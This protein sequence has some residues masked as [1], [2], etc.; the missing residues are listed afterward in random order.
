MQIIGLLPVLSVRGSKGRKAMVTSYHQDLRKTVYSC[1]HSPTPA[2]LRR[3][4]GTGR[5]QEVTDI[6]HILHVQCYVVR[7]DRRRW[8]GNHSWHTYLVH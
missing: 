6:D 1:V 5:A 4:G 7:S 8:A 3:N 2:I